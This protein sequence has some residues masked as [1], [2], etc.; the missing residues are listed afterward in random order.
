MRA[1][2][3]RESGPVSCVERMRSVGAWKLPTFSAREWRRAALD[4]LGANGSWTLTTS[5]DSAVSDSSI[6]RATSTGSE[7]A[8]RRAGAKGSTSPTPSTTGLPSAS[9]SSRSGCERS[10]RRLSRTS[11]ADSDGATMRTR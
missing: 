2:S 8:R 5:S 1:K 9:S 6:V 7:A 10:V 3:R 11:D 4:A